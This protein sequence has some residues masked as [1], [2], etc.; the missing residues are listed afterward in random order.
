MGHP[1]RL[2]L[3]P[4]SLI[5]KL[6]N[7]YTTIYLYMYI[8]VYIYVCV[9]IYVCVWLCVHARVYGEEGWLEMNNK[10]HPFVT[11]WI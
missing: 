6:A 9:R 4:T 5:V 1:M 10:T 7:H 2:E 8:Y 3:S 11:I